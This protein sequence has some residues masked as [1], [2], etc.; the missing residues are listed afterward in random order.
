MYVIG[1]GSAGCRIADEFSQ[2]SQYKI[3]KIGVG[4][5]KKKGSYSVE[6]QDHPEA[7]EENCPPL[8]NF[9]RNIKK[10]EDVLFVVSGASR[11]SAISLKALE[12]IQRARVKILYIV[13]ERELLS[14]KISLH[15]KVVFSVLQEYARSGLFE[16]IYLVA[17]KRI[18]EII[19]N[20]P[21]VGYFETINRLIVNTIHMIN[22]YTNNDPVYSNPSEEL[23]TTRIATFGL[24][25]ISENE[26]NLFYPLDNPNERCY[27]YAINEERLESDGKLFGTLKGKISNNQEEDLVS[28]V[29]I[30]ST[31][32]DEDYGYVIVSTSHTQTQ[33]QK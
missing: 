26:E 2:F 27:I 32:Y 12:T 13:P 9:F 30:H 10:N 11:I 29:Q 21:V 28:N 1:L 25:K 7:Y 20:V 16:K 17:N 19:E 8:K 33:E 24:T 6:P 31:N 14:R 4:L 5:P 3:L 23:T 15:E 18:E 22:V